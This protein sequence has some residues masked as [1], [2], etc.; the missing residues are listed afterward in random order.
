VSKILD[1]HY[2]E[3]EMFH[4]LFVAWRDFLAGEATWEPYSVI[5]VHFPEIEAKLM[6]AQ[7]DTDIMRK[8]RHL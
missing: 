2:N 6:R 5:A 3:Y 4:E 7:H 8:M 1:A